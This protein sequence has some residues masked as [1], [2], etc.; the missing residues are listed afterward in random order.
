MGSNG[1]SRTVAIPTGTNATYAASVNDRA[2]TALL[3]VADGGIDRAATTAMRA[4]DASRSGLPVQWIRA[5]PV[6]ARWQS[7]QDIPGC[8]QCAP[9][10]S[11][12]QPRPFG[13]K[14]GGRWSG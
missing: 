13:S 8:L 5:P 9:A 14:A 10:E 7:R 2:G 4:Y 3:S 11:A 6:Q 12:R 1:P